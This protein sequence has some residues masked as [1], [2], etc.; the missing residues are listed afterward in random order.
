MRHRLSVKQS[1]DGQWV[2]TCRSLPEV[3]CR[4]LTRQDA[5]HGIAEQIQKLSEN[6]AG[7]NRWVMDPNLPPAR[8]WIWLHVSALAGL[9]AL[10]AVLWFLGDQP[11]PQGL[12]FVVLP[13]IG[14][15]MLLCPPMVL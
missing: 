14:L 13:I 5:V 3:V 12:T 15:P 1:V 7:A 6:D 9:F 4:G 10:G 8:F 2:A 11:L